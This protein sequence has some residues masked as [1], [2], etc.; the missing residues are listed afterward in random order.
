[1]LMHAAANNTKDIVP[2]ATAGAT[3]TFSLA[4]S[5]IL[6]LTA[7]LMWIVAAFLLTRM[8]DRAID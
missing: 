3:N 2:S 7:I 6:W 5:P 8:R 4:A 1:M